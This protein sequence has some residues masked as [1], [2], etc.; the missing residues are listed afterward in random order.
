[1]TCDN[2]LPTLQSNL[3]KIW[4]FGE[5]KSYL[6]GILKFWDSLVNHDYNFK[7]TNFKYKNRQGIKIDHVKY[8]KR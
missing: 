1:M 4:V 3:Y 8:T 2:F 7:R 5:K 6:F